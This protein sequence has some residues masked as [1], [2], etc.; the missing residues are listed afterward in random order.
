MAVLDPTLLETLGMITASGAVGAFRE[1]RKAR[2]LSERNNRLL[3]G[4]D[5][6]DAY[7]GLVSQVKRH[8]RALEREDIL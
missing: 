6:S 2:K 8:E 7:D 5:E 3:E 1:T 4:I